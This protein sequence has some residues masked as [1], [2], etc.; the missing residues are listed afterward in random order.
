MGMNLS[1]KLLAKAAGKDEVH[2]DDHVIVKVDWTMAPEGTGPL[3]IKQ[4]KLLK[5]SPAN[6]KHT[7][8]FI[9]HAAPSPTR[10]TSNSHKFLREFA[11]KTGANLSEVG[12]G[13][14]HQRMVESYVSPGE[15]YIGADS[16]SC[17]VGALGAF[18]TGM[19]S[20]DVGVVMALG[21]TW[22]RVPQSYK[23]VVNGGFQ[24][25]VYP[26]DL[27]ISIIGHLGA[28]GA[29]YKALEFEGETI[30]EMSLSGRLTLANMAVE[31]GA[32]T[33]I[34]A[35]DRKVK[36]FLVKQGREEKYLKLK[37]DDDA[38]YEK[39]FEFDASDLGPVVSA[40]HQVDNVKRIEEV[41]GTKIDQVYLGTCTNG[42]IEDLKIA[43]KILKGKSRHPETRL[44]VVPA[45]RQIYLEALKMG[46]LEVFVKAGSSVLGP[47]CGPC[48][49]THEGILGDGEV[50]LSTQNRNFKGRMGNPEG[51]IYLSSPAT[52]AASVIKGEITDP[53]EVL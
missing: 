18:G 45:S 30:E 33:G 39:S 46:L 28:D 53:R 21:K 26:K 11:R 34:I 41:E 40:P 10:Q 27:I 5:D 3:A 38:D 22:L 8:Y 7:I 1:E 17:T 16:H 12:E 37:S 25:G 20:T 52:A 42:R 4:L 23:L 24:K 48:M 47:G 19:G 9:D 31:A 44:I 43:A 2:A 6:P 29:T 15:L 13:I 50:C 49:G 14:C 51:L 35:P 36:E 32:K